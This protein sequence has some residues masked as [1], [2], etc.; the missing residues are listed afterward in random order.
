[1][2]LIGIFFFLSD[3]YKNR[4]IKILSFREWKNYLCSW[5]FQFR[6]FYQEKELWDIA[7]GSSKKL[8]CV[9]KDKL[10]KWTTKNIK[11][12]VDG[13]HLGYLTNMMLSH[14]SCTKDDD[15]PIGFDGIDVRLM[16]EGYRRD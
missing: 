3:S 7:D 14:M 9:E 13:R 8:S 5:E 16:D 15:R 12:F 6:D 10:A 2:R 1:M 11:E 4:Q